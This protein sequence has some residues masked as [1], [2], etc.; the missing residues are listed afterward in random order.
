MS[1]FRTIDGGKAAG[2]RPPDSPRREMAEDRDFAVVRPFPVVEL[3]DGDDLVVAPLEFA[4]IASRPE[5]VR[6]I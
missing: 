2:E 6:V 1:N 5:P 3:A 4:S